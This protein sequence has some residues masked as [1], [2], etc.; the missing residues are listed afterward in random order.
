VHV[1]DANPPIIKDLKAGSESPG[2]VLVRRET[3]RA[4]LPALLA[5]RVSR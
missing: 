2:T 1:F 3:L 5:L 4:Q